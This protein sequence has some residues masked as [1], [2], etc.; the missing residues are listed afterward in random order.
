MSYALVLALRTG[1][2]GGRGWMGGSDELREGVGSL[3]RAVR[4]RLILR[5][6]IFF[7]G[8]R[9]LGLSVADFFFGRFETVNIV[10]C[11]LFVDCL[12]SFVESL[13]KVRKSFELGNMA[14]LNFWF[15]SSCSL[16]FLLYNIF[17]VCSK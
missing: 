5:V 12:F 7:F 17:F 6:I 8:R 10:G 13:V 2:Q 4:R 3:E 11:F 1:G 16:S 15:I 14:V 9:G